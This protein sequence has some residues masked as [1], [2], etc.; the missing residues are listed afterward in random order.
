MPR[1]I[2]FQVHL[3]V[4]VLTGLYICVVCVTGAAL[5]FRIDM[6]RALHPHLFTASA[7]PLADPVAVMESVSRAYPD[8]KLSGVEVPTTSRPTYLGYVTRGREFLTVL[9][10]P[11]TTDVLGVLPERTPIHTLQELHYDLLGG[12]TGR[13]INGAGAIGILVMC[14][15]GLVLWWPGIKAWR[16]GFMVDFSRDGRRV[17][18][19]L[20]RAIGIWSVAMIAMFAVTGLSFVFPSE[21]RATVN[22]VSTITVSRAPQSVRPAA[23]G[24]SPSW[25]EMIDRARPLAAGKHVARIVLPF[26]E[27]GAFLVMFAG[28][29]PTPAGSPLTPIYLDQYTGEPLAATVAARTWGDA[30]MA[31]VVP[32]HVGGYG[33]RPGKVAWFLFGLAPAALFV[34]GSIVWWRRVVR[35][36]MAR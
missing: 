18:W 32:L 15:T 30:L 36:R 10:D 4:G 9:I 27:R 6:Q 35:P 2:L 26:G 34:T 14:A 22:R 16:R 25:R 7:G 29:S 13:M 11:V 8:Y 12:R 5:V 20:H 21:F 24:L 1:R 23:D 17:I 28:E 33:G 31:A 3:W 19:E